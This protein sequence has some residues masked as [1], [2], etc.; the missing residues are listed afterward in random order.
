MD[1]YDGLCLYL[2]FLFIVQRFKAADWGMHPDFPPLSTTRP[3]EDRFFDIDGNKFRIESNIR[4]KQWGIKGR[5]TSVVDCV[6]VDENGLPGKLCVVKI[7]FPHKTRRLEH[8]FIQ[9]AKDIAA[10]NPAIAEYISG[11]V[12]H[13][14]YDETSTSHIRDFLHL[15]TTGSRRMYA[16]VL[17]RLDGPIRDLTGKDYW[18]TWWDCFDCE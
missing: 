15:D 16:V 9:K 5:A 4:H 11:Y 12:A 10:K 7:S 17:V 3:T 2:A 13:K 14:V 6:E 18:D 1:N 8:E